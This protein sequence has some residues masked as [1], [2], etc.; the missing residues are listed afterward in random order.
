MAIGTSPAADHLFTMRDES[1]AKPLPPRDGSNVVSECQ[2]AVRHPVCDSISDNKV[3]CPDEDNWGKVK[4]LLLRHLKGTL[5]MPLILSA[6]CLMLS[7]WWV[8]AEYAVH[9]NC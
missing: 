3:R 4:R 2:R 7:R 9:N 8:D 6:N 1:M 5:N